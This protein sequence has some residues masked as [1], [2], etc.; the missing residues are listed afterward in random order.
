MRIIFRVS[1]FLLFLLSFSI[2]QAQLEKVMHQTFEVGNVESIALDLVGEYSVEKWAGNTVMTETKVE[3]YEASPAILNHFVSKDKRYE[4]IADTL[5]NQ[6]LLS[7]LDKERKPIRTKKKNSTNE[8]GSIETK[9]CPEIVNMRIFLP[10]TYEK[11]I[12]DS[13]Q[14]FIRKKVD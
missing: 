3:L 12:G 6:L 1:F 2:A 8:D 4:V 10:D 5:N 14:T 7:S 13:T 9:E 11:V